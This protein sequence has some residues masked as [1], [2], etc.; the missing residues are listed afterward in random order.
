M[1]YYFRKLTKTVPKRLLISRTDRIGDFILTL[2]VFEAIKREHNINIT[3][4]C[5]HIAVPL[6]KNNP[7]V[8]GI[9]S[10]D[11]DFNR[12]SLIKE[13]HANSFDAL[14]VMVN[15]PLILSLLPALKQIPI[16]I[17]PLSKPAAFIHYSHPVLQKRSKSR[18][19]EAEYNLELL[20]VFNQ[21]SHN[22]IKPRLYLSEKETQGFLSKH[23]DLYEKFGKGL[24][25][26]VL[27]S[28]MNDSAL[29]MKS[30]FY[31]DLLSGL[32][33]QDFLV[34]LTGAGKAEYN[35]NQ[36]LIKGSSISEQPKVI[37][38]AGWFNL[39]ELAILISLSSAYIGPST[40]PTHIAN[41][42]DT[43]LVSFYPPI[44]VQSAKRWEP[45]LFKGT[46][47]T[48]QVLCKQKFKCKGEKCRFFYC[49]D[50]I[51]VD[52]VLEEV[53]SIVKS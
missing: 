3:V 38:S 22:R 33:N 51:R 24:K 11:K 6:L 49:M 2:P 21:P 30:E 12:D 4:L 34:W 15:D 19:N 25:W 37:N 32:L 45:Y 8:D 7:F 18:K 47:Y 35:T 31:S 10:V 40:G 13:I 46:I 16:R 28:G 43:P 39:R 26:I 36:S 53:V 42:V 1:A 17:G 27:H 50:K 23:R 14:L 48:P 9:I 5:N 41:A 29:N 52:D 44:S 20:K